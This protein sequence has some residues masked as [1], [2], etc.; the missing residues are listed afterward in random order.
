MV[1]NT[2]PRKRASS[3]YPQSDGCHD[4]DDKHYDRIVIVMLEY[5]GYAEDEP[6]KTRDCATRMDSAKMLERGSTTETEPQGSPLN[7]QNA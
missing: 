5:Q 2:N 7:C 6:C 4:P 3:A 1:S